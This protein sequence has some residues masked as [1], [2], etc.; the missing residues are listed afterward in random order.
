MKITTEETNSNS[1]KKICLANGLTVIYKHIPNCGIVDVRLTVKA[2]AVYEFPKYKAGT[3]HFLEHIVHE[4]TEKYESKELL[5]SKIVQN[6]GQSNAT[7]YN[8]EK[9]FFFA[10]VLSHFSEDAFEYVSQVAFHPILTEDSVEKH[11]SIITQEMFQIMKSPSNKLYCSFRSLV[12]G[13]SQYA[14]H[15]IGTEESIKDISLSELKDFHTERF[16]PENC[17]LAIYGDVEEEKVIE[18]SEKYFSTSIITKV[19]EPEAVN[20]LAIAIDTDK[21]QKRYIHTQTEDSQASIWYGGAFDGKDDTYYFKLTLLLRILAGD[22]SSILTQIL[23]DKKHL[24]YHV[25]CFK[26]STE[27]S[28]FFG[29]ELNAAQENI[30][31]IIQIIRS[32]MESISKGNFDEDKISLAK[33]RIKA[34]NVFNNQR[35]QTRSENDSDSVFFYK[36]L[37]SFDDFVK[38]TELVTKEDIVETAQWT[39]ERMN[40]LSVLSKKDESFEF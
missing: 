19:V 4:K 6:G 26:V 31:E 32:E 35:I 23:R 8:N 21:T 18:L 37:N 11:R 28:G 20:A 22:A 3:A 24:T 27:T 33:T 30:Q 17:L 7:T 10:S 25:G 12:Y 5:K 34:E 40:I 13:D 38:M 36:G 2:G 39:L 29:F 9:M 16:T 14:V 15:T 1:P